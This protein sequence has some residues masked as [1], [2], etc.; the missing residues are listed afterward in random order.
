MNYTL[1]R[2]LPVSESSSL[3]L[4]PYKR[5]NYLLCNLARGGAEQ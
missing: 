3:F 1:L 4:T 2:T 5:T